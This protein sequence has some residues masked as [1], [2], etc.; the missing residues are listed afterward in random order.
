MGGLPDFLIIGAQKAGTSWLHHNLR[1][2]PGVFMPEAK[3]QAYFCW[4]E[5]PE[6]ISLDQYRAFFSARAEGQLAGE[7]TAAYFWTESG[8]TWGVKPEGYCADVPKRV[9]DTLGD[10]TRLILSLRDPVGRAVSAYLHHI[11]LGDLDP[12][13]SLLEAGD[14]IGLIDIGFYAAHLQNWLRCFARDQFLVLDFEQDI[15]QRPH[16]TLR[17]VFEF[18]GVDSGW[19]TVGANRPVFEGCERLW[20]EDEVWVPAAQYPGAPPGQRKAIDGRSWCRR[21]DRATVGRLRDIYAADQN[22]L[23][24]LL[25]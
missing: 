8:S 23:K 2:H 18:L 10:E 20:L 5:G 4:C 17:R 6:A 7:A 24:K 16:D 11:V 19:Q 12:G 21:V 3:D 22:Q 9:L 13:I 15:V 1:Q 25:G 14:F